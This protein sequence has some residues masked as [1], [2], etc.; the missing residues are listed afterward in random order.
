MS[1]EEPAQPAVALAAAIII[2]AGV[3][4]AF[5]AALDSPAWIGI[6]AG[7]GVVFWLLWNGQR[8]RA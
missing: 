8:P 7:V 5:F 4:T 1:D 6:G 3:G 2:G